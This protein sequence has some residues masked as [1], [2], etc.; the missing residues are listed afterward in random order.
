MAHKPKI[1]IVSD[2]PVI[3]SG[4][5][6]G[7]KQLAVGLHET[8]KYEVASFGWFWHSA[9]QQ[10][11]RWDFPWKQFTNSQQQRPY[12]H[13]DNWPN[14]SEQ[15]Y[16][17]SAIYQVIREL[18]RPDIVIGMGDYWMLDYIYK[19]PI[20]NHFKFIHEIPIDG[21]PVPRVWVRDLKT[22]DIV[23]SM[24][25]YGKR[26]IQDKDKY[27]NVTVIPR[28]IN[29]YEFS[30]I[31]APK[32]AIREK[33]MPSAKGNFV[34]GL[35]D[36][37]QDRKQIGRAIEAFSKF[38]SDG[39]HK[40]CDLYLHMDIHDPFSTSQKKT[41]E[42]EDGLFER[43]NVGERIILNKDVTVEKGLPVKDL[44]AI[45]NCC[46][47]RLSTT[48][49]EGF[50]LTIWEAMACGLP[51]I[52]TNYTTPPELLGT[53][54]KRGLL[55]NVQAYIT[56]MYNI[57]RALVDT[58]HV[59]ELLDK[60]YRS[61]FLRNEIGENARK[62][63][64]RFQWGS[65][66]K[67]WEQIIDN[68]LQP[69]PYKL[70]DKS[71][72]QSEDT[73][74]I[75]IYGAVRENTGWAITTRGIAQGFQNNKWGVKIT[76]GGGQSP[77]F[78]L[79]KTVDRLTEKE[80]SRN[81]AFINHMPEHAFEIASECNAKYK[82]VYFPFELNHMTYDIVS[83]L[84]RLADVYVCPSKFV[85]NI[86]RTSGVLNTAVIPLA[87]DIDTS[88]EP[89]DLGTAKNYKFLMLGNLGDKR[90]NL[91]RTV[92]AYISAFTGDDD[93]CLI[94]KS[95]P[96]HDDSDPT[97]YIAGE[98]LGKINPP[99]IKVFHCD[100]ADVAPYFAA[101]DCLLMPSFAEGW[102]HPVFQALK[103][104]MPI[105]ASNYGGYLEFINRG[106]NV[107]LIDGRI[108]LARISPKFKAIEQWLIPNF[109]D[110]VGAMKK[111]FAL[112]M[113]KTGENYVAD[114]NWNKTAKSI[115]DIYNTKISRQPKIK[116]YYERM[117]KNLW[118]RDN[119]IG[120][121]S[122]APIKYEFI[123]DSNVADF[124]ILDITRISDKY[125]LRCD[126]Y[127]LFF[128]TFGEWAEE[129]PSEYYELFKN[130]MLVYSHIDLAPMYP[131]IEKNK[132]MLGPWGTQPDL[133]FKK[134]HLKNDTYQIF[135]TGEI[136]STEGIRECIAACDSLHKKL[137]HVGYDFN[138]RN[139]S[140]TN[141]NNLSANEMNEEYNNSKW[142][143][144]LR[145]I[146]GFEKPAIEGL[147]CGARPI[148]FDTPLYRYWYGDLA[149]YVKEGTEQET[150]E[151]ILRVMKNEYAPV[152]KE[153]MERAIK[154]F[155][156]FYVAGNFWKRIGETI[157]EGT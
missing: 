136:P 60:L 14:P 84:N 24:S 119:E 33:Y 141:R 114:Y 94:L 29:T 102:G 156:W 127:I 75:N 76:E 125:Y 134:E 19:F 46:D 52:A 18:F 131:M 44:N 150:Y 149:R 23:I 50:G 36:R 107:Q 145:R 59:A 123:K 39:K 22:A 151:D 97:E 135:C 27:C 87:S 143:S 140:Y 98:L 15:D 89:K 17:N 25:Q 12:G 139:Y 67:Q 16:K 77:D 51:V 38:I 30:K 104:G 70:I 142:V 144:A 83:N 138:Y 72:V 40:N 55:A 90:K 113:R 129:D 48:Q 66:I 78:V 57:E 64:Q 152:T 5:G 63:V 62:H 34:V 122:Y 32:D 49:G 121:K 120:F 148:C 42:G 130:A 103:F 53:D 31:N 91:P 157:K 10:K 95:M 7:H 110:F 13:P 153:E 56:G 68:C 65:V 118:N 116:I 61:P 124:Q 92:K 115:E 6:I 28:G 128:H 8:G 69:I 37:F 45:Y 81:L 79:D 154:K 20:R 86:A 117:I 73:K 54:G 74:E 111:S 26:V 82:I 101:C 11:L 9:Q 85:E 4:M 100:D 58:T 35:F 21:E 146:E 71:N 137:L 155:A 106:K 147:L 105:I 88:A 132:F 99:E 109:D 93:V 133:W 96:G 80:T 47:V 3:T 126:K 112:N 108:E 1:L 41:I 43:Y 2:T